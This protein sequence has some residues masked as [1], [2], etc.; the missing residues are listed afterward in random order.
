MARIVISEFMDE[1]AVARLAARHDVL[2][3]A[4]LVDDPAR[5]ASQLPL[6]TPGERHAVAACLRWYAEVDAVD[7]AD[8]TAALI[9]WGA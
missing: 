3:D 7:R 5:R 8:A 2:Y 9:H 4:T 1:R 6:F